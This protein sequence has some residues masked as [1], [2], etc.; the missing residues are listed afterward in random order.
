MFFAGAAR[1]AALWAQ[2]ATLA[3]TELYLTLAEPVFTLLCSILGPVLP[4]VVVRVLLFPATCILH[5]AMMA[6]AL[7]SIALR[8]QKRVVASDAAK[9]ARD[10]GDGLSISVTAQWVC[11]ARALAFT[12]HMR[13]GDPLAPRLLHLL[14]AGSV[15]LL[16]GHIAKFRGRLSGRASVPHWLRREL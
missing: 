10:A 14:P 7:G 13:G 8:G 16:H 5:L 2:R 6:V 3:V 15:G 11:F 4:D 9:K 12:L 1:Y